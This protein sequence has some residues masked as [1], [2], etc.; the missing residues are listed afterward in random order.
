MYPGRVVEKDCNLTPHP[1]QKFCIVIFV[2]VLEMATRK[3]QTEIDKVLKKVAEGVEVFES[4]LEKIHQA[5]NVTQKEKLEADLK[6]EIKKLQKSRDQIKVWISSNDIKD[7]KAL[8][9]NRKLIESQMEKFKACEKELKTKAYSKEGLSLAAKVDPLEREKSDLTAWITEM[10]EKLG[11]QIDA[12]EAEAETLQG[13]KKRGKDTA[14]AERLQQ[15]ED[16]VGRH[17]HHIQQLEI[18]L[19]MLENGKLTVDA[20]KGVKESV[21][22]YVDSNQEPGFEEDEF[23]YDELNLEDEAEIYGFNHDEDRDSDSSEGCLDIFDKPAPEDKRKSKEPEERSISNQP[24]TSGKE[25]P[26]NAP[27][28]MNNQLPPSVADLVS[29]FEVTKDRSNKAKE[30]PSQAKFQ[31]EMLNTS[32]QH[33]PESTDSE[34]PKY[35]F[36]E[37][38]YPTP[39]YFPDTPLSVFENPAIFEMYLAARELKKHA[40]RFHKKYQTWFQ[41]HD[42]PKAINDEFEQG[43]YIYFDYENDW[44]QRKKNDFRF[45]YK[46]L[47]DENLP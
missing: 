5:G 23:I 38:P 27:A 41:R 45:E 29:S 24:E 42:E 15:I 32:F 9:D 8:V 3:L 39:N 46:W 34:R 4:I 44:C 13:Q 37:N 22:Y 11:A 25:E 19:R 18:V 16:S 21:A 47:E 1:E 7:K 35:Y 31:Q 40:W 26:I 14:K 17:K 10:I 36:P 28:T 30:D 43:T 6:K 2:K 12:F 20:V 33:L